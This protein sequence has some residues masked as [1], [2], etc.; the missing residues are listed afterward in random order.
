MISKRTNSGPTC[1][2]GCTYISPLRAHSYLFHV[3]QA[4]R[5]CRTSAG[6]GCRAP[7]VSCVAA[8]L[9]CVWPH[10]SWLPPSDT[11]AVALCS[12]P[13]RLLLVRPGSGPPSGA[14]AML[15]L[16]LAGGS[17]CQLHCPAHSE[18]KKRKA[19]SQSVPCS[20]P[21]LNLLI[22]NQPFQSQSL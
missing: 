20:C 18:K 22:R 5:G 6:A 3:K 15:Y 16:H 17:R 8:S 12:P 10:L 7:S 9:R 1:S 2:N 4:P 21:V 11:S 14:D 19:Y 13:A